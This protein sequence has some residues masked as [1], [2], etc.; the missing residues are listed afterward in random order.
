MSLVLLGGA[1]FY[2]AGGIL[3]S[4]RT[5]AAGGDGL[6]SHPHYARWAAVASLVAD[7]VAFSRMRGGAGGQGQ[8]YSKLA[9]RAETAEARAAAAEED[10]KRA[11]KALKKVEKK[12]H[13]SEKSSSSGDNNRKSEKSEKREKSPRS[14]DRGGEDRAGVASTASSQATLPFT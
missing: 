6:Q 14:E 8:G 10:A 5:G 12:L 7:G 9:D 1:L 4:V 13:S 3:W 2:A 11:Q